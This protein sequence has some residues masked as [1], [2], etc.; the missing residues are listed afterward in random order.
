M[1]DVTSSNTKVKTEVN[2]KAHEFLKE[3]KRRREEDEKEFLHE[4]KD[5]EHQKK[6]EALQGKIVKNDD[7]ISAS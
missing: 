4:M 5:P 2:K 7:A 6:M 1:A 3:W